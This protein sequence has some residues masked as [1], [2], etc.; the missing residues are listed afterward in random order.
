MNNKNEQGQNENPEQVILDGVLEDAKNE[1][2]EL[3]ILKAELAEAEA[4]RSDNANRWVR[5]LEDIENYQ[6]AIAKMIEELGWD[7][8]TAIGKIG[9]YL[10]HT[11]FDVIERNGSTKHQR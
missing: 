10:G 6:N 9:G 1:V 11:I 5:A 4:A 7:T 2:S 8:E 3:A